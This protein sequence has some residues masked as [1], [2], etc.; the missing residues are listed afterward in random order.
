MTINHSEDYRNKTI[1]IIL[2]KDDS[3][4]KW[5]SEWDICSNP[6]CNCNDM[7]FKLF[8]AENGE[9]HTFPR[10]CFSLDVVGK[11]AVK[12]RGENATSKQDFR[13][14]KSFAKDLSE[15]DWNELRKFYMGYKR[16]ITDSAP[17]AEL[18]ASFPEKE[19]EIEKLMIGYNEILPHAEAI[20]VCLGDINYMIDDQYCLCSKCSCKDAVLTFIPVRDGRALNRNNLLTIFLDY[21]K[22]SWRTATDG[23]ENI[24]TPDELVQ[25][26]LDKHLEKK[27]GKRHKNLRTIYKNYRK[28]KEKTL[29][30]SPQMPQSFTEPAAGHKKIGRNEPCPCGSGK[31]F[32]KCCMLK[33]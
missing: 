26:I 10:H 32:K 15:S 22:R 13:F 1:E 17:I 8:E 27:F 31:K 9:G 2:G 3:E 25:E 14:A 4:R 28:E 33:Q 16:G 5:I 11:K 20:S 6:T 29:R 7:A 24:A 21:K 19:I 30:R 12:L 23:P 18:R